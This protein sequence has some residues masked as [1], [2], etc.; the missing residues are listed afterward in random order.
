MSHISNIIRTQSI[1]ARGYIS[2]KHFSYRVVDGKFRPVSESELKD[3]LDLY[4]YTVLSSWGFIGQTWSEHMVDNA[5]RVEVARHRSLF[6]RH[7]I[8]EWDLSKVKDEQ[9]LKQWDTVKYQT[10]VHVNGCF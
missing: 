6:R 3:A 8:Y 10:R 7:P 1:Y 2:R 4:S 5:Y 9:L